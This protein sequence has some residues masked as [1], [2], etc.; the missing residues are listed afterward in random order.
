VARD[1]QAALADLLLTAPVREHLSQAG[2]HVPD[3]L[4]WRSW[5][6]MFPSTAGQWSAPGVVAGAAF[7]E[8]QITVATDGPVWAGGALVLVFAD[9]DLLA[10]GTT[11][12][13]GLLSQIAAASLDTDRLADAGLVV[14]D[15]PVR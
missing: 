5:P 1:V 6:Q 9:G 8:F 10:Y 7:T 3:D 2:V 12:D 15:R 14:L 13:P 11:D 4:A